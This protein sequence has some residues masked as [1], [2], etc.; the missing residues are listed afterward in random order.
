MF[1]TGTVLIDNE[2][3]KINEEEELATAKA[4]NFFNNLFDSTNSCDKVKDDNCELRCPVVEN[5][6][7]HAFW[8]SAK[9]TLGNMV[10]I[11]KTSRKIVNTVRSIKNW[12]FTINNF[13]KLWKIVHVKF[14]FNKLYTRYCN[15]DPLENFFGQ[16]R[17]HAVRHTN[18]TPAQFEESFITLLVSNMKSIKIIGGNC[19]IANNGFMLF[20]LEECL[21]S[22]A[23][24]VQVHDVRNDDCD[25]EPVEFI[26]DKNVSENSIVTLLFEKLEE[27]NVTIFKKINFCSEC[28]E[29]FKNSNFPICIR[30]II[31]T[32]NKL[33]KTRAHQ[34]NI[35]KVIIKHFEEWNIN[36]DWHECIEH[37][38]S[39]F[40]IIVRVIAIKTLVWWCKKKNCLISDINNLNIYC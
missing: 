14:N 6:V 37:H 39:I 26:T 13:Q 3:K 12:Y 34:K 7:H 31:C 8:V 17:S 36:L 4:V 25:D 32:I 15:Q 19:E 10:F 18:P 24:N 22:D 11:E 2:E 21:K 40:K 35:L 16:I 29:S 20:L 5:S 28:E 30:Q 33:L 27:I 23:S 38:N 9:E 1:V